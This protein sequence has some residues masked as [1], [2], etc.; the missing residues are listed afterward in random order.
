MRKKNEGSR[1]RTLFES[2]AD[3]IVYADEG[4]RIIECNPAFSE[5]LG[6][7]PG[8]LVGKT[9]RDITPTD[10]HHVDEDIVESQIKNAGYS[11]EYMKEYLTKSG[12]K[13]P[14]SMRAWVVRDRGGRPAGSWAV[15]RNMRERIQYENFMRET[16]VRLDQ[17][18]DRL[19]ELDRL[20]TEL[21][22][23]VSHELRAPLA[24]IESSIYAMRSIKLSSPA[25]EREELLWILDRGVKRL[26]KLVE[27]L[28][29][30]T[31][32]ESGQLKL[33]PET[34]DAVELAARVIRTFEAPFA[35][36]G[37]AITLESPDG[38]CPALF[39]QRRIEQVL[40]NLVENALKWTDEGGVVLRVERGPAKTV[41]TVTD[42]G[43]GI[44]QEL[45]LRV[46][47]KF[48]SLDAQ[49]ADGRQGLGLGLAISK[50]IVEAHGGTIWVESRPGPG[51]TF[52]FEIPGDW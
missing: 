40:T 11:D 10:W 27:E 48:F 32:I 28:M 39:D 49:S 52:R 8:E 15:I 21:V 14:V 20:K 24:A 1:Y 51:A 5:M 2:S 7:A 29:D 16:L 19:Q 33:E 37:V 43:P 17:A 9:Y 46:F 41:F 38:D 36:K 47:D 44:A 30:I 23:T 22:A 50:G 35:E 13:I 42:S 12:A 26:S 6:Y 31:R 34:S 18:N 45:Q 4:G 3:G 25:E